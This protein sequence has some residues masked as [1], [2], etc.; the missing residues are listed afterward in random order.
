L[1]I[2][3]RAWRSL[4]LIKSF[5]SV[6]L[7][8]YL[9]QRVW[10]FAAFVGVLALS[11]CASEPPTGPEAGMELL[12]EMV[13]TMGGWDVLS[14]IERQELITNGN[15]WEPHQAERPGAVR[16]LNIFN[17][18]TLVDFGG[19]SM[20]LE[21]VG[22]R[23]YPS[24]AAVNFTDV[25]DGDVGALVSEG[26]DG[27]DTF[28]RMQGSR[29]AARMR[30]IH[31]LPS[32]LPFVARESGNLVRAEDRT[33]GENIFQVLEFTD[34]EAPVEILILIE[35][36]SKFPTSVTYTE[37]DPLYGDTEN[38]LVYSDWRPSQVAATEEGRPISAQFPFVET[39]FLNG[40]R[41]SE[42]TYRNI[43]NNGSFDEGTFDI[44]DEVR[45]ASEPGERVLSQITL[46][47]A[48]MGFGALPGYA[49][50]PE[51]APLEEIAPG[52][53]QAV[54]GSHNS[55]IVEMEGHLI[56]VE[57]PL[58]EERSIGVIEAIEARFPDKPI[59]YTI[60]THFHA[61][62]SGGIRTYA[63]KG[64]TVVAHESIVDFLETVV[65]APSTIRPDLLEEAGAT[66]TV[67]GVTDMMELSDGTRTVQVLPV[68][69][70][71]AAGM[72]MV[73]LPEE[74]IVFVSDLYS[75]PNPVDADNANARA[76]YD[77]VVAAELD[78]ETVVGGHGTTGSFQ[79]LANVMRD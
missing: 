32:Q 38:T 16:E 7:W 55:M 37:T 43:I 59:R 50:L 19:P 27:E 23:S 75:P 33:V 36:F 46:R 9:M 76:F 42:T 78:V 35:G 53:L 2:F 15:E 71:H 26:D 54:G 63:A 14:M 8:G 56:V 57:A 11:A 6:F 39:M 61:D 79:N 3:H 77:A 62:H 45:A 52:V 13:T 51:V 22:T 34:G 28:E 73:Y 31:R 69:N 10:I 47:R 64:A 48:G 74:G 65:T 41:Y 72:V 12:D 30:D 66:P 70:D 1:L 21:F 49:D 67:E 29:F 4:G 25:I 60:V 18:T 44:P 17:R 24:P 20:R 68:P 5:L 58:F 40:D